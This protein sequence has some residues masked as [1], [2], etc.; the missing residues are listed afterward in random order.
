MV[1]VSEEFV[2]LDDIGMDD[3]A[4]NF[5]FILEQLIPWLPL[6]A[7]NFLHDFGCVLKFRFLANG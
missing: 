1:V 4:Q 5:N 6:G 3:V 2:Y 7:A